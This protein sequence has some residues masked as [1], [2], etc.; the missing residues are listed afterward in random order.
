MLDWV[1]G[2]CDQIILKT[3]IP[4]SASSAYIFICFFFLSFFFLS[5]F[6]LSFFFL[7]FFL[8]F[9][10]FFFFF[11][12]VRKLTVGSWTRMHRRMG[13]FGVFITTTTCFLCSNSKD[14]DGIGGFFVSLF[15]GDDDMG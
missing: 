6:F 7:S 14:S 5:F 15:V 10:F 4:S 1:G 3:N 12:H 9:F 11:L 2:T 13:G 8:S